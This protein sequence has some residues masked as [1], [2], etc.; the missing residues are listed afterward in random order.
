[1][2]RNDEPIAFTRGAA[3]RIANAVRKVEVGDRSGGQLAFE[4]VA[5]PPQ[6]TVFRMATFTGTWNIDEFKTVTLYHKTSTPNTVA[7]MNLFAQIN[8]VAT[9]R[10]C[11]IARDGTAW[12]LIAA[13]C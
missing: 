9:S 5:A 7:A 2:A 6:R 3:Q 11:A 8:S 12:Y 1:M 10:P 4:P 13:K